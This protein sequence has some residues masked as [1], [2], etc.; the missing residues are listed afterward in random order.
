MF[1]KQLK[2]ESSLYLWRALESKRVPAGL[3][4]FWEGVKRRPTCM[5]FTQE[6]ATLWPTGLRLSLFYPALSESSVPVPATFSHRE[7]GTIAASRVDARGKMLFLHHFLKLPIEAWN[8]KACV[9]APD[10][11]FWNPNAGRCLSYLSNTQHQ[12][13]KQLLTGSH[14]SSHDPLLQPR[15]LQK[16]DRE[17]ITTPPPFLVSAKENLLILEHKKSFSVHSQCIA[18]PCREDA[19]PGIFVLSVESRFFFLLSPKR[20]QVWSHFSSV[21]IKRRTCHFILTSLFLSLQ[22][23]KETPLPPPTIST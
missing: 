22:S 21:P 7:L 3:L 11:H 15:Y 14:R 23:A 18:L 20:R 4:F 1:P 5:R 17:W 2:R 8:K 12:Q 9:F 16:Q 13:Y 10:V 6:A 19:G